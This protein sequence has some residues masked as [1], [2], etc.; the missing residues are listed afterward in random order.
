M[1]REVAPNGHH[2]QKV[3]TTGACFISALRA[4]DES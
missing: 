2:G 4:F 3:F 1:A